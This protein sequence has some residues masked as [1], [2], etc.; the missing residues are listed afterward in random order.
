LRIVGSHVADF[1][2]ACVEIDPSATVRAQV[3]WD[4]YLD[5][6]RVCGRAPVTQTRLG[7]ELYGLGFEKLKDR[8]SYVVYRAKMRSNAGPQAIVA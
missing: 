7:R 1:A 5:W 6:C 4:A 2:A 3:I 8:H